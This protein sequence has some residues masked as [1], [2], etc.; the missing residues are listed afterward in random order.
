MLIR[1]ERSVS[2][3]LPLLA[4]VLGPHLDITVLL[5]GGGLERASVT[6]SKVMVTLCSGE[7]EEA[8]LT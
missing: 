3:L 1:T 8:G 5:I 6:G 2:G 7:G 4:A